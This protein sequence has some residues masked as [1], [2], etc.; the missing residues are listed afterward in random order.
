MNC[1][2]SFVFILWVQE[3]AIPEEHHE[4]YRGRRGKAPRD[5]LMFMVKKKSV[6][7]P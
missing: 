3:N 1:N 6:T 5:R 2:K 4:A 7:L